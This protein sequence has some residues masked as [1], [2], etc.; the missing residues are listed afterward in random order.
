VV[1]LVLGAVM[2]RTG[3][4]RRRRAPLWGFLGCMVA[5]AVELRAAVPVAPETWLIAWGLV[6]LVAGITLDRYLREPRNGLTSAS[7]AKGEGPFDLLQMAG[8]ALLT[9]RATPESQPAAPEFEGRG[10][11]FGGGGASGRY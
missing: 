2:L 10:G 11:E 9:H 3:L 4:K 1:L 7:L 5:L 6:A 8:A